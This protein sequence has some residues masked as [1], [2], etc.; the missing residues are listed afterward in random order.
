MNLGGF[1]HRG[2]C[3]GAH[4]CSSRRKW[5]RIVAAGG[6]APRNG[7]SSAVPLIKLNYLLKNW[8]YTSLINFKVKQ[9]PHPTAKSRLIFC[10]GP[11]VMLKG[12]ARCENPF[13]KS[14]FICKHKTHFLHAKI[15]FG[16]VFARRKAPRGPC[17]FRQAQMAANGSNQKHGAPRRGFKR[18]APHWNWLFTRKV[19]LL[20]INQF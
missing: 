13:A 1:A 15:C 20:T 6:M 18:N 2:R 17:P 14:K 5:Q 9:L 12:G 7:T 3:R 10:G 4:A 19:V 8:F 16:G 11:P